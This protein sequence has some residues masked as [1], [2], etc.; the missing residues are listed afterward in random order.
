MP[1]S[2]S[3]ACSRQLWKREIGLAKTPLHSAAQNE[4]GEATKELVATLKTEGLFKTAMET[5]DGSGQMPLH[6]AAQN[7]NGET[8]RGAQGGTQR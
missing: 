4:N 3:K 1:P 5:R 2:R 7:I 8:E 6:S